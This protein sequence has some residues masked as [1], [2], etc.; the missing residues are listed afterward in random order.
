MALINPA[1]LHDLDQTWVAPDPSTWPSW[2]GAKR[3]SYD[4]ET[5][6]PDLT[7]LGPSVRRGGEIVGYCVGIEDGPRV[8]LPVGHEA[9]GNVEN[10]NAVRRYIK[11][12][13]RE[14]DG[15]LVGMNLG[16]DLDFS[17]EIGITFPK[18][19]G[20][21]DVA[22]AEALIDENLRAYSL[23]AIAERR[24]GEKK[25]TSGLEAALIAHFGTA[26]KENLW[27]LHAS[28]VGPYGMG[29]A[30]LPLRVA[31]VQEKMISEQDLTR[32]FKLESDLIP[33]FVA[34]KRLGIPVDVD[35]LDAAETR[36]FAEEARACAAIKRMTGVDLTGRCWEAGACAEALRSRGLEPGTTK[37]GKVSVTKEFLETCRDEV[38]TL[39]RSARKWNKMRTTFAAQIRNHLITASDGS[40]R[41]H[42][43]YNQLKADSDDS[44]GTKGAVTGR[45]SMDH[46]N[47]LF[48]PI[49]DEEV[50]GEFRSI[51]RPEHG[52]QWA[53]CD[54]SQQEPR[55]TIDLACRLG[56]ESAINMAKKYKEDPRTDCHQ[57]MAD[58]TGKPRTI[59]KNIYLGMTYGMGG[60]K[61]CNHYLGLPTCYAVRVGRDDIVYFDSREEAEIGSKS[62]GGG[63]IWEEA[64]EEGRRI[65]AEFHAAAPFLKDTAN[66]ARS[67]ANEVGYIRTIFG[68]RGRFQR[69]RNGRGYDYTHK[70]LN[71]YVQGS[72]ADQT[73][74]AMLDV[75]RELGVVP[76]LQVYDE[77]DFPTDGPELADAVSR[78]MEQAVPLKV[79]VIVDHEI[80]PSWGEVE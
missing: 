18:I 47:L 34:I 6:D 14:F 30:D 27:R 9:G 79:P 77:L 28:L 10:P 59:A 39:I 13:A 16:Y 36:Y 3:V 26:G 60:A 53:K 8:Y 25:V 12:Q 31:R 41:I 55:I 45:P 57:A 2:S 23:D 65:I 50:G 44:R 68:R 52:S 19:S 21:F 33:L 49:R 35:R 17:E 75:W 4:V 69:K 5:R 32:V 67:R 46:P 70:A 64:G 38:G 62:N 11:D 29:D 48:M 37:T 63:F 73:K 58:L 74:Q 56:Y 40:A 80:G 76:Y 43:N 54:I 78:A 7:T 15:E 42:P 1:E 61:L 71:K 24:V 72:A 20:I 66:Y 22:V 51:F